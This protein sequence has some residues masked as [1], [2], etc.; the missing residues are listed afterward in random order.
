METVLILLA[1]SSVVNL[2]FFGILCYII[3]DLK[4]KLDKVESNIKVND[5]AIRT[6]WSKTEDEVKVGP[7]LLK[8]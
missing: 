8:G 3:L 6:M 7:A 5:R 1:M 4:T 2:L